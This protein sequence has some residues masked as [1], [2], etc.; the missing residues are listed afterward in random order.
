MKINDNKW[1]IN[2]INYFK[3][4]EMLSKK[5]KWPYN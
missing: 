4:R 2:A 3:L 1:E 5:V